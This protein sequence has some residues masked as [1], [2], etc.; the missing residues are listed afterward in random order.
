MARIVGTNEDDVVVVGL[1]PTNGEFLPPLTAT[2]LADEI[3]NGAGNDT[4]DASSGD[5]VIIGGNGDDPM[6]GG[7]RRRPLS[8]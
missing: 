5:D 4:I 7:F 1:L 2:N 3:D 6:V 8:L